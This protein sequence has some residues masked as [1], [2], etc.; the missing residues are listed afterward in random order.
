MEEEIQAEAPPEPASGAEARLHLHFGWLALL[1]FLVLGLVLEVLHA[2]K[3]GFYLEPGNEARRLM[4]SLAHAHGTL[5]ALVNLAFAFTLRWVPMEGR[6]LRAASWCLLGAA[7]VLPGG[8]LLGGIDVR[9]G[10]P[11]LGAP[12]LVPVGGAALLAGVL[13]VVLHLRGSHPG[14]TAATRQAGEPGAGAPPP[15]PAAEP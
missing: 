12:L 10:D 3:L 6:R 14:S 2:F 7:V 5:L 15:R 4:W 11:G 13:L 8:F 9:G 1:F